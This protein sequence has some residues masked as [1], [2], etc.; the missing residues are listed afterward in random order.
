MALLDIRKSGMLAVPKGRAP[1]F[2][3][4]RSSRIR[5]VNR[6]ISPMSTGVTG[7]ADA[8]ATMVL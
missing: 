6:A 1:M 2:A 7:I 5:D 8:R 3:T 4:R